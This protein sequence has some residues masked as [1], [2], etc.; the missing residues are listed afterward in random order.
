MNNSIDWYSFQMWKKMS[1][2]KS[3]YLETSDVEKDKKVVSPPPPSIHSSWILRPTWTRESSVRPSIRPPPS[4]LCR[5]SLSFLSTDL[6]H[7]AFGF[8]KSRL[9][10]KSLLWVGRLSHPTWT[11]AKVIISQFIPSVCPVTLGP[12]SNVD[13]KHI[14]STYIQSVCVCLYL[15]SYLPHLR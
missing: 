5:L 14:S 13:E 1:R 6:L 11:R 10:G 2:G 12:P 9:T 8:M 7:K 15:P 4:S 3:G